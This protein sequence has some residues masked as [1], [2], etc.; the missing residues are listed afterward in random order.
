MRASPRGSGA[1]PK[2]TVLVPCERHAAHLPL[3]LPDL[4]Q[5]RPADLLVAARD[6]PGRLTVD[7]DS[8]HLDVN[9][10]LRCVIP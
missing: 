1:A 6:E 3:C 4:D 10:D 5:A 8:A 2:S 7:Y 9:S